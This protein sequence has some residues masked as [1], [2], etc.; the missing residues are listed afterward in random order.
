MQSGSKYVRFS[1]KHCFLQMLQVLLNVVN[2]GNTENV[3]RVKGVIY[4]G[5]PPILRAEF[6]QILANKEL[7][8]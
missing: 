8:L 4:G 3:N 2:S 6:L 5:K 1:Q 7:M